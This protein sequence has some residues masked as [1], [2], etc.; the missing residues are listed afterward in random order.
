[1][2]IRLL[3]LSSFFLFIASTCERSVDLDLALLPPRLVVISY[4]NSSQAM[5]VEV[6][7]TRNNG[8]EEEEEFVKDAIVEIFK[9]DE[10]IAQLNLVDEGPTNVDPYYGNSEFIPEVD[11]YYNIK[12]DAPGFDPVMARSK[13]PLPIEISTLSI[14]DLEI[15]GGPNLNQKQYNFSTWMTFQDPASERN[16]YQLNF[17]QQIHDFILT[18]DDTIITGSSMRQIRFSPINDTNN[19]NTL[20]WGGIIFKDSTFN[21]ESIFYEFDMNI[22]IDPSSE[23]LGKMFVNLMSVSEEFY[24]YRNTLDNQ[25][26]SPGP[27][28]E[29]PVFLYN[30]IENGV[31]VFAGYNMTIDSVTIQ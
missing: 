24:L 29:E 4:F 1:M 23:L 20:E 3:A 9:G 18:E 7:L 28:V 26:S 27:P 21:G 30:N 10:F 6:T 5:E 8:S 11:V 17:E 2:L 14:D 25:I 31:G 22:S 19:S 12:V 16:F 13:I 15:I